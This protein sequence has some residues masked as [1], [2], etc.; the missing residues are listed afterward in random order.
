MQRAYL[1]QNINEKIFEQTF[2]LWRGVLTCTTFPQ[3]YDGLKAYITNKYSLQMTQP[4]R[5][6]VIYGVLSMHQKKKTELSMQTEEA[7][8][9]DK[10]KCYF[11]DRK[12]H[13]MKKC[14]YYDVKKTLEQKKKDAAEE[15]KAK[16]KAKKNKDKDAMAETNK[17]TMKNSEPEKGKGGVDIPHKGTQVQV[18]PKNE[19]A[20]LCT[21]QE[22]FLYY[23]PC[24]AAGVRPGQVDFI[25]DSGTVSGVTGEKE[26]QI[27]KN[28]AEEDVFIETVTGEPSVSKLYGDTLFGKTRIL[29]GCRGSVLV[30]QYATKIYTKYLTRVRTPLF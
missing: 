29:K 24:A 2:L 6:K 30:S 17:V 5:A 25:Y 14:W 1:M 7:V 22:A 13:N 28:V 27:L 8:K 4:D 10:D 12:G 18:P 16:L 9:T 20:G 3:T 23:K 11:C 19:H 21:I 15:I 26:M